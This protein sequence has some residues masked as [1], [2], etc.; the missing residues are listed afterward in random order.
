MA[1]PNAGLP[2]LLPPLPQPN[3]NNNP[4]GVGGTLGNF[5]PQGG[6][7]GAN[8]NSTQYAPQQYSSLGSPTSGGFNNLF[9]PP[10]VPGALPNQ[11][12][13]IES[14]YWQQI[15]MLQAQR[16]Q[17][18]Q[19]ELAATPMPQFMDSDAR[20]AQV[21]RDYERANQPSSGAYFFVGGL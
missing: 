2:G 20:W 7:K 1:N 13:P 6:S 11:I 14:L 10:N 9:Q 8:L 16:M 18:I 17:Q 5:Q 12:D 15:Q 4:T 19:Q 3:M 21:L